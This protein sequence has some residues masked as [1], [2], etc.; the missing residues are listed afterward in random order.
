MAALTGI[1][2]YHATGLTT[3]SGTTFSKARKL[4][5]RVVKNGQEIYFEDNINLT[6]TYRQKSITFSGPEFEVSSATTFHI[7]MIGYDPEIAGDT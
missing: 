6:T 3:L 1:S 5:I 4:G 2:F 7:Q